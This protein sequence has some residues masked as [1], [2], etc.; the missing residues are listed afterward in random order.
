MAQLTVGKLA[1][2]A[3]VG[4]E[5][6]RFYEKEGLMA[7]PERLASGYR[8]YDENSLARLK[9]IQK[10][11]NMGFTLKETKELLELS[12][13]AEADCGVTCMKADEKI[14]DIELRIR[15]LKAMKKALT[16]L[17]TNCPG[18]GNPLSDCAILKYFHG[19]TK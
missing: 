4:V 9:F 3:D 14:A 1:K 6:V 8:A 11:K 17:R 19:E 15:G 13:S 18:E 16:A 2:A 10:A 7:E 5:T 12:N